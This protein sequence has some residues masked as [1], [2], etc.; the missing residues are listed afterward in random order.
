MAWRIVHS[1]ATPNEFHP[2][3]KLPG[4]V[5]EIPSLPLN[6]PERIEHGQCCG[7]RKR[8]WVRRRP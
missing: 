5:W 3:G 4:S 6:V 8:P 2:L 7:G 1:R